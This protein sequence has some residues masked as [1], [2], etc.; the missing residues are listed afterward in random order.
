MVAGPI[1]RTTASFNSHLA[2][3]K[4]SR[5]SQRLPEILLFHVL[6]K[7]LGIIRRSHVCFMNNNFRKDSNPG[8]LKFNCI[9]STKSEVSAFQDIRQTTCSIKKHLYLIMGIRTA[10]VPHHGHTDS[11]FTPSWTY[12]KTSRVIKSY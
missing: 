1:I 4:V 12:A 11:I 8:G 10:F 6:K 9:L 3:T 7:R 2:S 5:I